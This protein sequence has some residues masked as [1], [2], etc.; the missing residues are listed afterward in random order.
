MTNL[1]VSHLYKSEVVH[2]KLSQLVN[3]TNFLYITSI[4]IENNCSWLWSCLLV[5]GFLF[6]KISET[7]IVHV[8]KL[9]PLLHWF[10]NTFCFLCCSTPSHVGNHFKC[11]WGYSWGNFQKSISG[12]NF[13]LEWPTDVRSTPLSYIFNA[14]FRDTPLD[15]VF[16]AQPNSQ[17]AKLAKYLDIWLFGYLAARQKHGQV[18]YPWKEHS[19]CSSE[20]LTLRP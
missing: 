18:G 6:S 10:Q 5:G 12:H 20:V 7:P 13:W 11:S 8:P 14:L 2:V 9:F 16:C 17:I 4:D 19:K 1:Q 3:V 15:H